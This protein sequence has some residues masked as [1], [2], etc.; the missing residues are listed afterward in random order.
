[1][2]FI[3]LVTQKALEQLQMLHYEEWA[4][5]EK[6]RGAKW[7]TEA[8]LCKVSTLVCNM[9]RRG[10]GEDRGSWVLIWRMEPR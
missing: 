9:E 7:E 2:L 4:L 6:G 3:I 10:V 8:G 5:E 1:M